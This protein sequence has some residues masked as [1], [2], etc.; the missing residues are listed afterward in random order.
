MTAPTPSQP[1]RLSRRVLVG[2]CVWLLVS[3]ALNLALDPPLNAPAW[4]IP[5]V[6]TP[7]VRGTMQSIILGLGLVWPAWRLS[8]N[9][10]SHE[11]GN[12]GGSGGGGGGGGREIVTDLTGMLL[13]AQVMVW[14]LRLLMGWS[15]PYTLLI[16][17]TLIVWAVAFGV[18]VWAGRLGGE[19]GR[20][21]A[22]IACAALL[23]GG[24]LIT[25][26]TGLVAFAAWSPM[27]MLWVLIDEPR[28]ADPRMMTWRLLIVFALSIAAWTFLLGRSKTR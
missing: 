17:L 8:Q 1:H 26:L 6:L 11:E 18:C 5:E 21:V 10:T 22:M 9:R 7:A 25:A 15:I 27:H 23:A 16:A 4:G 12:G 14:L 20:V 2:W 19:P 13:V 24:W 28:T 3:W